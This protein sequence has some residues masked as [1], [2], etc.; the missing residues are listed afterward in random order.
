MNG[1]FQFF[2]NHIAAL[3]YMHIHSLTRPTD[4]SKLHLTLREQ[5]SPGMLYVCY[6]YYSFQ[7]G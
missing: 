1:T 4:A 2:L 7:C 6:V 5:Y 3:S